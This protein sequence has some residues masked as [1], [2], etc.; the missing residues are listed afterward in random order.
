MELENEQLTSNEMYYFVQ[1]GLYALFLRLKRKIK[2]VTNP[3]TK[4]MYGEVINR[5]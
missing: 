4:Y 3:K 1:L 2:S 5:A